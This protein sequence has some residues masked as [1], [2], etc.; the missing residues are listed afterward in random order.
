M[1]LFVR[2]G[3]HVLVRRFN[4]IPGHAVDACDGGNHEGRLHAAEFG[5][6]DL[7][8][9]F[10]GHFLAQPCGQ[11]QYG[12]HLAAQIERAKHRRIALARHAGDVGQADDFKHL[13]YVDAVMPAVNLAVRLLFVDD[14]FNDFKFIIVNVQQAVLRHGFPSCAAEGAAFHRDRMFRLR[15]LLL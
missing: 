3:L 12:Q 4:A 1:M 13:G 9:F 5:Y 6:N 8:V 10:R 15:E 7:G 11:I 2:I 14:K